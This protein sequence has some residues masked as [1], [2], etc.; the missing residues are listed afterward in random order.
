M[1]INLGRE[2]K[3]EL[4]KK[5]FSETSTLIY[6]RSGC[7]S[8]LILLSEFLDFHRLHLDV[9]FGPPRPPLPNDYY[10]NFGLSKNEIIELTEM[11]KRQIE[12]RIKYINIFYSDISDEK[13]VSYYQD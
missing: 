12:N 6:E 8:D 3:F 9:G 5:A 7:T 4:L 1:V 13:V 10:E 2:N 11:L